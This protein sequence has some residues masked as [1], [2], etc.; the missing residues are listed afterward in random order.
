MRTPADNS[1]HGQAA[2][3]C[4]LLLLIVAGCVTAQSAQSRGVLIRDEHDRAAKAGSNLL[5][6]RSR[7]VVPRRDFDCP[8]ASPITDCHG[9]LSA[10]FD[11]VFESYACP[12]MLR[13]REAG[14]SLRGRDGFPYARPTAAQG[15]RTASLRAHVRPPQPADRHDRRAALAAPVAGRRA[16]RFLRRSRHTC[17][18][19]R[20]RSP[21]AMS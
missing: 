8:A 16:S 20:T 15:Q 13:R 10:W 1:R 21:V 14:I 18:T 7:V 6:V 4:V 19:S 12:T 5:L 2:S 3:A 9:T 11:V 17:L